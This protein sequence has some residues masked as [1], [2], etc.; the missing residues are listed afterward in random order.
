MAA[1]T[2][3]GVLLKANVLLTSF[4]KEGKEAPFVLQGK[5]RGGGWWAHHKEQ[6]YI[7]QLYIF[8][9]VFKGM[10]PPDR[11]LVIP[12]TFAGVLVAWAI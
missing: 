5:T 11:L 12:V 3:Q 6:A 1:E 10:S 8:F 7:W 2:V 4:Q 9:V